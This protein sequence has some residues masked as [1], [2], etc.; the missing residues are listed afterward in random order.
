MIDTHISN[1]LNRYGSLVDNVNVGRDLA[2]VYWKPGNR[3]QFLSLVEELTGAPLSA[4]A[5]VQRLN[6]PTEETVSREKEAYEQG[7]EAG[8]KYAAGQE[9]DLDMRVLLVHGDD[10]VADS[11]AGGGRGLRG[12]C[13]VYKQWL[14]TLQN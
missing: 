9:V 13:E 1:T 7:I 14:G 11:A 2:E 8:P 12:A 5:W 3:S 6:T 10:V 4:S